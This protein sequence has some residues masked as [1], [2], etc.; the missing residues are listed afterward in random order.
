MTHTHEF[1]EAEYLKGNIKLLSIYI[2]VKYK[3]DL[4]CLKCGFLWKARYGHFQNRNQGCPKCSRSL[5]HSHEFV[6]AEYLKSGIK[7]L[8]VYIKIIGKN[9]LECLKCGFLWK[10]RYNDFQSQNNGCP[11]CY[12]LLNRG[13]THPSW[14]H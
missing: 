3:N 8:S 9:D 4:E 14:N 6:K 10:A 1:A 11:E 2:G 12:R 13:E 5:T 7:L